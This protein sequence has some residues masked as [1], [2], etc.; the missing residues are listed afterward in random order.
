MHQVQYWNGQDILAHFE[1]SEQEALKKAEKL[2]KEGTA[3]FVQVLTK[4]GYVLK[5]MVPE[6]VSQPS[7]ATA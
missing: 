4:D 6:T 2:L 1:V 5:N 7:S 3:R